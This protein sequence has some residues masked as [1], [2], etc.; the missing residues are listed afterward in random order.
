MG[1][2]FFVTLVILIKG[3][4]QKNTKNTQPLSRVYILWIYTYTYIIIKIITPPLPLK[5]VLLPNLRHVHFL[6]YV[7]IFSYNYTS[8]EFWSKLE[9][10][11]AIPR[12]SPIQ[13]YNPDQPGLTSGLTGELI[14][15]TYSPLPYN[16]Q[17]I[18]YC[19]SHTTSNYK[20]L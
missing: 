6:N 4:T 19:T 16:Y 5:I 18:K 17:E 9:K 12:W 14:L 10:Q 3:Q 1:L 15:H 2:Q 20:Y 13:L 7:T 8:H 11:Q